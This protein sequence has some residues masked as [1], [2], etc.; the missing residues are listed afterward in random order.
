MKEKI[1]ILV[2][3]FMLVLSIGQNV[4]CQE[5]M[6]SLKKQII[7]GRVIDVSCYITGDNDDWADKQCVIAYLK[8]GQPAGILEEGTNKLYIVAKT[9]GPMTNLAAQ[10]IPYAGDMV[11]IEGVVHN[12]AGISTIDIHRIEKLQ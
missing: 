8:V 10:L 4:Y 3:A 1:I 7:I 12:R 5:N 9:Q 11:R 6:S 2:M